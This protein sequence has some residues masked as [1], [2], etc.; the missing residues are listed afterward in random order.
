MNEFSQK[1][2]KTVQK[3]STKSDQNLY[4]KTN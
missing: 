1:L 2:T 4:Y 3:I